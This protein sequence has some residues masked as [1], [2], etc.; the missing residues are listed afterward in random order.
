MPV[1][2]VR[3]VFGI[4]IRAVSFINR[5]GMNA[6]GPQGSYKKTRTLAR[7]CF[8]VLAVCVVLAAGGWL[9]ARKPH[10]SGKEVVAITVFATNSAGVVIDSAVTNRE[11][12]ALIFGALRKARWGIDH[13]CAAVGTITIEYSNGKKDELGFLPSHGE[14]EFEFR[15][16]WLKYNL[17]SEKIYQVLKA[18]GVETE[19]IP[20]VPQ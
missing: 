10:F 12:C 4:S 20:R 11:A 17:A 3:H 19:K 6:E 5:Q 16:R 1:E 8:W 13:K 14:D 2:D 7:V 18:A 9:Y 15:H